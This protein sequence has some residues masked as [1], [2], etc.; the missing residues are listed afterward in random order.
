MMFVDEVRYF[1]LLFVDGVFFV[2]VIDFWM[3]EWKV[4]VDFIGF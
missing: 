2:G 4:D 3:D 1:V